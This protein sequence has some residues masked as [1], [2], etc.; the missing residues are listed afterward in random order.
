MTPTQWGILCR[1]MSLVV[2]ILVDRRGE[3]EM[4]QKHRVSGFLD[5]LEQNLEGG[6]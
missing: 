2:Y 1:F 5:H 3:H 4:T 6:V